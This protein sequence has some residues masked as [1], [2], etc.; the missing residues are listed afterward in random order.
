MSD[1]SKHEDNKDDEVKENGKEGEN[2][3]EKSMVYVLPQN[4]GLNTQN[5]DKSV[6]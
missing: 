1:K 2:K 6:D 4:K 3:N 5:N